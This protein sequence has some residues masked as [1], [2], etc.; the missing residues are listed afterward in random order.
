[1]GTRALGTAPHSTRVQARVPTAK[2]RELK[3]NNTSKR[4][5]QE[6][7]GKPKQLLHVGNMFANLNVRNWVESGRSAQHAPERQLS[8]ADA[9]NCQSPNG[10]FQPPSST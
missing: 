6:E 5:K 10:H 7:D 1:M 3:E 9:Q 4:G 8:L 2:V